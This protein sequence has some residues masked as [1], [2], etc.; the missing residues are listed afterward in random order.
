M[1]TPLSHVTEELYTAQILVVDEPSQRTHRIFPKEEVVAALLSLS[2]DPGE[3]LGQLGVRDLATVELLLVS[4]TL[5]ELKLE[6]NV[7]VGVIRLLTTPRGRIVKSL[8]EQGAR[9]GLSLCCSGLVDN[10]LKVSNIDFI[11]VDIDAFEK[12]EIVGL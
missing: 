1:L 2:L 10:N 7:L 9:L 6:D 12:D 4:H 5:V 11:G 3:N 8:L